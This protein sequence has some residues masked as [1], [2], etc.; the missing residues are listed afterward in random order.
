VA[1]DLG[2]PPPVPDRR[3]ALALIPLAAVLVALL[4]VFF[5]FFDYATVSGPSMRPTL[6]SEDRL[7]ITKSYKVAHRGDIIV[8]NLAEGGTT[9][10]IVKRVIGLPGDVVQVTDDAAYVNGTLETKAGPLLAFPGDAP[11]G[12]ETV[13]AGKLFVL[14]DNRPV[15]LDSR[16]IGYIPLTSVKGRAVAVFAPVTRLRFI[17]GGI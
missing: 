15:S 13:P 11:F 10:E 3:M 6:L 17:P 4:L 16:F 1:I 2:A 7:L 5:V 14:G 8:F 9:G 12:P